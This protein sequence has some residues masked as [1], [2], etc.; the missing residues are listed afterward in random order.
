MQLSIN[1]QEGFSMLQLTKQLWADRPYLPMSGSQGK[2]LAKAIAGAQHVDH[3]ICRSQVRLASLWAS[4]R[5]TSADLRQ[6]RLERAQLA[7]AA[8]AE[9]RRSASSG[10]T[11]QAFEASFARPPTYLREQAVLRHLRALDR[12]EVQ[13]R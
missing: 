13:A 11:R 7:L 9:L 5:L 8:L 12:L 10:D 6:R 1:N 2:L 3:V 4:R